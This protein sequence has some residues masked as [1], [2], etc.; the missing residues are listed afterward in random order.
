M[1]KTYEKLILLTAVILIAFFARSLYLPATPSFGVATAEETAQLVAQPNGTVSGPAQ[2]DAARVT[3][4]AIPGSL[5]VRSGNA[6]APVLFE[7]AALV[8]D[9]STGAALFSMNPSLRWPTASL[10]K[11]I[12][13]T[14]VFDRLSL[15]TPIKI[16]PAAF[17]VDPEEQTIAV[18]DTYSV[19]DLLSLMLMPSDNVAAEALADYIGR[20]AILA[21]MNARAAAWGMTSTYFDDP[22]G[23]SSANESTAGDMAVL[24]KHVYEEYPSIFSITQNPSVVIKELNS[25]RKTTVNSIN[26]FAGV[27]G[28]LGGKTGHTNEAGGNLLSIFRYNGHPLLIIVLGSGDRFGDTRALYSWFKNNFK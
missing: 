12:T 7:K 15:D 21:A 26:E 11:L 6:P 27:P 19:K 24:A 5:F 20:D 17:T 13:A 25:G 10:T 4:E 16:T 9:L 14:F 22:S 8:T 23:I 1:M 2:A 28:F 3:P 18:G